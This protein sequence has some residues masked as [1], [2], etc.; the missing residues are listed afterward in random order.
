MSNSNFTPMTEEQRQ[1]AKETRDA[2]KLLAEQTLKLEYADENHWAALASKYSVRL[3][4]YYQP[5]SEIKYVRRIAK[6]LNADINEFLSST[7]Y[8]NIKSLAS[9]N[10][11]W[12]ARAICG[13]FLEFYDDNLNNTYV[14]PQKTKE[15]D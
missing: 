7:G 12:T 8:S 3:P 10:P 15:N 6:K 4:V 2:K 1:Q 5:S 14:Y 13:T 9:A 11:T